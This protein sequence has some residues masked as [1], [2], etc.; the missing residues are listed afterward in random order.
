MKAKFL[1]I[2]LFAL[3]TQHIKTGGYEPLTNA[4]LDSFYNDINNKK[5]E[6]KTLKNTE[7]MYLLTKAFTAEEDT[8]LAKLTKIIK[9]KNKKFF[10]CGLFAHRTELLFNELPKNPTLKHYEML[11]TLETNPKLRKAYS[12]DTFSKWVK[13]KKHSPKELATALT[14][15]IKIADKKPLA[16][17]NQSNPAVESIGNYPGNL[18]EGFFILLQEAN[19]YKLNDMVDAMLTVHNNDLTIVKQSNLS[20]K[21]AKHFTKKN[22]LDLFYFDPT[23]SSQINQATRED[24]ICYLIEKS[25]GPDKQAKYLKSTLLHNDTLWH[26][27]QDNEDVK[28]INKL[29]NSDPKFKQKYEFFKKI[30][31]EKQK[32]EEK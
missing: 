11:G 19:H 20:D 6:I 29:I 21:F 24:A 22:F 12:P 28:V 7:K 3:T 4:N 2:G 5:E 31:E 32:E 16:V 30:V 25:K 23:F 18:P 17:T 9:E 14:L 27:A 13:T 1:F 15:M 26:I 8:K 10:T